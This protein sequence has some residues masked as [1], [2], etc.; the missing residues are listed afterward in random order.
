MEGKR[1]G[2]PEGDSRSD[3]SG[4]PNGYD[5]VGFDDREIHSGFEDP[6]GKDQPIG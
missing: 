1:I 5:D 3:I 2:F 4:L 6:K